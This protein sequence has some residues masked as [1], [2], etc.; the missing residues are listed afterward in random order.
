MK[1]LLLTLL[2]I[3]SSHSYSN[4]EMSLDRVLLHCESVGGTYLFEEDM[5]VI[6][7]D[8]NG[9]AYAPETETLYQ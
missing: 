7:Y 9:T 2:I 8:L 5:C 1:Y 6:A 4:N 3:T